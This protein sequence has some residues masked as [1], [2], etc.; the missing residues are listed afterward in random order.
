MAG[1]ERD[2]G[3]TCRSSGAAEVLAAEPLAEFDVAFE[4]ADP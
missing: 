4:E 3:A 1:G 2:P